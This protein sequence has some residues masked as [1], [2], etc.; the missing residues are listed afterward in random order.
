MS[1]GKLF[2]LA[3]AAAVEPLIN[4]WSVWSDLIAPVTH[5]YHVA[6]YQIKTLQSYL[7]KPE[8]HIKASQNPKLVGGPWVD[9]P[10]ARA[11]EVQELRSSGKWFPLTYCQPV[12]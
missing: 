5:S 11:A 12:Q 10:E 6:N 7:Q 3:D 8:I 2:R 9:I 1:D 4:R